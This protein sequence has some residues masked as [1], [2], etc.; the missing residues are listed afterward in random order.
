MG[1]VVL[2]LGEHDVRAVVADDAHVLDPG[3]GENRVSGVAGPVN[4]VARSGMA[5]RHGRRAVA[6]IA[7]VPE[8]ISSIV[9]DQDIAALADFAIPGVA[10]GAGEDRVFRDRGPGDQRPGGRGLLRAGRA[11]ARS[12][13]PERAVRSDDERC[14]PKASQ[15][16][17]CVLEPSWYPL[18]DWPACK[19]AIG[20]VRR[21]SPRTCGGSRRPTIHLT[22]RSATLEGT[23][24]SS[25]PNGA[26]AQLG[27]RRVRN[28]EVEG[29]SPFRSTLGLWSTE[30]G[31]VCWTSRADIFANHASRSQ[32][33]T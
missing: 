13:R 7:G 23:L 14:E 22:L 30:S 29:S 9:A 15:A 33:L 11:A 18:I 5:Q 8:M 25:D 4:A 3:T 32:V 27:E 1:D 10:A 31:R 21:K 28:A 17:P 6:G 12:R 19:I 24:S 26:V 20:A 2:P 16:E